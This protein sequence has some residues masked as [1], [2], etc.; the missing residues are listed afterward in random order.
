MFEFFDSVDI[1]SFV[2]WLLIFII[3]AHVIHANNK[4][5]PEYRFFLLH[6][7]WKIGMGLAFGLVYILYY[8]RH[9]DTVFYWQGAKKLNLLL[10]DN[11]RAYWHELISTPPRDYI[12]NYFFRVGK[13][14][15]WIY[16]EPNSWFVCKIA[17]FF[18]FFSFGSYLTLNLFFSVI[19]ASI[20]WK[21]FRYMNK[22]LLTKT[23]YVALA[24]LFIPSVAFWCTGLIKDTIA[25]CAIFVL[26]ICI[27]KIIRKE[28]K[29]LAGILFSLL[30]SY[31]LLYSIR[32][33]LVIC[34]VIPLLMIL[35]FKVNKNKSFVI[36]FLTRIFGIS[37]AIGSIAYYFS[38]AASFGEYSAESVF[39]TA[40][41]IQKDMLNN[42]GYTGKRY[43]LS[44]EEF[45]GVNLLLVAP[46]AIITAL[47]RPFVWEADGIFILLNGLE[48]LFILYLCIRFFVSRK[49]G[50]ANN[51]ELRDNAFYLYALFLVLILGYFVGL[52]S[53]LFGT[54]VRLKTPI[55]PF[56]LLI[57]LYKWVA[58][59]K[60]L[61]QSKTRDS[62][63]TV[64]Q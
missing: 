61:N 2:G 22:I 34:T 18:S 24:C 5:N 41:V 21:F 1:V 62:E 60:W 49:Q 13:P 3:I 51:T 44:I 64:D 47:F 11:P 57:I 59:E 7:Y 45:A 4:Q 8:E 25:I 23:S 30:L 12:P 14:P 29:S 6:F 33:F 28:Y 63:K 26:T 32:P 43:Y 48:N 40:E 42:A 39:Q 20:S 52:T 9:G 53:G 50:L 35:I 16:T 38:S 17:N 46:E 56:F 36:K 19:S 54:L 10:F 58:P 15:S 31:Y 37:L 55:M 27:L